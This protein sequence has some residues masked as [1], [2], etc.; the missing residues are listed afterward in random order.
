[1]HSGFD[2]AP[3]AEAVLPGVGPEN[4]MSTVANEVPGIDMIVVGHTHAQVADTTINGV[5]MVQPRNWATSVSVATLKLER[6]PAVATGGRAA[7]GLG[8]WKVVAKQGVIVRAAGHVED[9]AILE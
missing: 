5:L 7:R 9:P 3:G 4:V 2:S 8:P 1:A 6:G